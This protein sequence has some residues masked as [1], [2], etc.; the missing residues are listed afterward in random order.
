MESVAFLI[1]H[2]SYVNCFGPSCPDGESYRKGRYALP[3]RLCWLTRS[4][5]WRWTV[6]QYLYSWCGELC[7]SVSTSRV[8]VTVSA[9]SD[10]RSVS[11]PSCGVTHLSLRCQMLHGERGSYRLS[12]RATDACNQRI[13]VFGSNKWCFY[14]SSRW[15]RFSFTVTA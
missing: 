12:V 5:V 15:V 11:T 10:S 13:R 9:A 8:R 6:R 7:Q 14:Q 2:L 1:Y 3:A 4:R